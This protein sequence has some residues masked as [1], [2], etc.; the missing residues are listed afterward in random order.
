LTTLKMVVFAPMPK[1]STASAEKVNPGFFR[2]TRSECISSF[3]R[4]RM[5]G[6]PE[7]GDGC[8]RFTTERMPQANHLRKDADEGAVRVWDGLFA[9]GQDD[10]KYPTMRLAK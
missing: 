7:G 9:D 5:I 1:L 2:S 10:G 8:T 3:K 6:R 4:S